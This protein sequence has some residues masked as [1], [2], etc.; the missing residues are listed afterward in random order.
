MRAYKP[1]S[2]RTHTHS[3]RTCRTY[4]TLYAQAAPATP[5]ASQARPPSQ[6]PARSRRPPPPWP[7]PPTPPRWPPPRPRPQARAPGPRRCATRVP[8]G[9]AARAAVCVP[10]L[11][12]WRSDCAL[13]RTSCRAG[14][15]SWL[16]ARAALG[17]EPRRGRARRLGQRRGHRCGGHGGRG[18]GG[19]RRARCPGCR[20][21]RR[22]Q[23]RAACMHVQC[24]YFFHQ[25]SSNMK[26][27]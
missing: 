14:C 11:G 24:T 21:L 15:S 1:S 6:Q 27:T 22:G 2:C 12:V 25:M 18:A 16:R 3:I 9:G 19:C 5:P 26:Q 8:G 4:P 23:A 7:Q 13:R 20:Q 10:P 17:A